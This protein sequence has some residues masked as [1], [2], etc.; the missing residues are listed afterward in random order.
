[1]LAAGTIQAVSHRAIFELIPACEFHIWTKL[2]V[3]WYRE[4]I[5]LKVKEL[6]LCFCVGQRAFPTFLVV[7][8][9]NLF[10]TPSMCGPMAFGAVKVYERQ[11][12]EL[13]ALQVGHFFW[14]SLIQR[15]LVLNQD[16]LSLTELPR[17]SKQGDLSWWCPY[18]G[19]A[20][21]GWATDEM[22]TELQTQL[23]LQEWL[24]TEHCC[25]DLIE[26]GW[27]PVGYTNTGALLYVT[28]HS[29]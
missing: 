27:F 2:C 3:P 15:K 24:G 8:N 25:R 28:H 23:F 7:C 29:L 21:R 20:G 6:A 10:P 5:S 11:T 22:I 1:M 26:T 12:E 17:M 19:A 4:A 13:P 16:F 18:V 9:R 14:T